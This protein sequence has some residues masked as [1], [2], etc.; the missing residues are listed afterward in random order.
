MMEIKGW[1]MV[2]DR[3]TL[4]AT[5]LTHVPHLLPAQVPGRWAVSD[6]CDQNSQPGQQPGSCAVQ[7]FAG[8]NDTTFNGWVMQSPPSPPAPP[9]APPASPSNP[10]SGSSGLSYNAKVR[11]DKTGHRQVVNGREIES[12]LGGKWVEDCFQVSTCLAFTQSAKLR[13]CTVFSQTCWRNT[14]A[15][16]RC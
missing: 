9:S 7:L 1:Q 13:F 16:H 2:D 14:H 5:M 4:L 12:T 6:V 8:S 10:Q 15:T 3:S 11:S